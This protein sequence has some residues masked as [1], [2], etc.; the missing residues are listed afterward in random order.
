MPDDNAKDVHEDQVLRDL[1]EM[2]KEADLKRGYYIPRWLKMADSLVLTEGSMELQLDRKLSPM[3]QKSFSS[4]CSLVSDLHTAFKEGVGPETEKVL[5]TYFKLVEQHWGKAFQR[6]I[7]INRDWH[8]KMIE[9]QKLGHSLYSHNWQ[10]YWTDEW[11]ER[12]PNNKGWVFSA[13]DIIQRLPDIPIPDES[14]VR[15]YREKRNRLNE[16]TA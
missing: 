2:E 14:T 8:N 13:R 6:Q 16:T 12:R 7:K 11:L 4:L 9:G 10:E 1:W 5:F 15:R 3:H